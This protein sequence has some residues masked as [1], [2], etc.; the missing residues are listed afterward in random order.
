MTVWIRRD[1]IPQR[2]CREQFCDTTWVF[3]RHQMTSSLEHHGVSVWEERCE[4]PDGFRGDDRHVGRSF[5]FDDEHR[6][7]DTRRLVG[8]EGPSPNRCRL[9]REVSGFADRSGK[10][11]G[12]KSG[13]QEVEWTSISVSRS[14][15]YR[16]SAVRP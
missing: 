11:F 8:P 1:R 16:L 15:R 3:E 14:A 4:Q 5:A 13:T 10:P 6:R 12:P 9:V 7:G 2:E